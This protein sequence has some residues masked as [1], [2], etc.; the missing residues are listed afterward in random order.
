MPKLLLVEA[1]QRADYFPFIK[2]AFSLYI[3]FPSETLYREGYEILCGVK[4]GTEKDGSEGS[5]ELSSQ[6]IS[7]IARGFSEF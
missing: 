3:I 6:P 1:R 2:L 7:A 4:Y 5:G